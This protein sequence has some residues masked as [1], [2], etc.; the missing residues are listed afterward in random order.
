MVN[1]GKVYMGLLCTLHSSLEKYM[2]LFY[3]VEIIKK[4]KIKILKNTSYYL[5]TLSTM[6]DE[7]AQSPTCTGYGRWKAQRLT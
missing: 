1:L 6:H 4:K 3:K 2:Q 7:K 5:Y